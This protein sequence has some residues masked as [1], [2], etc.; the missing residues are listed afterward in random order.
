MGGGPGEI[1]M[2]NRYSFKMYPRIDKVFTHKKSLN[3]DLM[4]TKIMK[5][6]EYGPWTN[7]MIW[8]AFGLVG[9]LMGFVASIMV[10]ME[11]N[12]TELKRDIT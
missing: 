4:R 3:Y 8:F 12:L 7:F 1:S 11:D 5:E 2:D 6:R 10:L 9:I